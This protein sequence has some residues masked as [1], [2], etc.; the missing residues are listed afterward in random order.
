MLLLL[1]LKDGSG[2]KD[3][4]CGGIGGGGE[5]GRTLADYKRSILCKGNGE[6]TQEKEKEKHGN[7]RR[8]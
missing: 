8:K 3:G 1:V 2:R 7:K 5:E 6:S 4:G